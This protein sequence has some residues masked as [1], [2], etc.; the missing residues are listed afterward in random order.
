MIFSS[1]AVAW[2]A[3]GRR[4][5]Y[6]TDGGPAESVHFA[7]GMAICEAAGCIVSGILGQPLRKAPWGL[8]AAADEETHRALV[9]VIRAQTSSS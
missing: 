2:V 9:E 8:I 4:A 1:L 6:V 3:V 7:A 5:A